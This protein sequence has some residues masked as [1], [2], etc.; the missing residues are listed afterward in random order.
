MGKVYVGGALFKQ[1]DINQRIKEANELRKIEGLEVFNP[2]EAP[3]N[4]KTLLPG[5]VDIFE[6]DTEEVLDSNYILAELDA[7]I[8]EGLVAEIAIAWTI[9]FIRQEL[10]DMVETN[11]K[12]SLY[13]AIEDWLEDNPQKMIV[14]HVSDIRLENAGEYAGVTIPVGFNQYVIG[15]LLHQGHPIFTDVDSAI[16]W[17]KTMEETNGKKEEI[18]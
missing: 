7:K 1:G 10:I 2:I 17:I 14:S 15:M 9:N 16:G 5:A 18:E 6:G 4:D 3:V 8:D 11:S 12:E 13:Q